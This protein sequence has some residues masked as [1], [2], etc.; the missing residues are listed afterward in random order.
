MFQM[1]AEVR[2]MCHIQKTS[3]MATSEHKMSFQKSSQRVKTERMKQWEGGWE[4]G[5]EG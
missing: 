4:G 5:W 2:K 1:T 3:T